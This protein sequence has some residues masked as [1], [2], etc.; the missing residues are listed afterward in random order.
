M[1]SPNASEFQHH[2]RT[3]LASGILCLE[4]CGGEL[5]TAIGCF[6]S[7]AGGATMRDNFSQEARREIPEAEAL[8]AELSSSDSRLRTKRRRRRK[9]KGNGDDGSDSSTT[10]PPRSAR[11]ILSLGADGRIHQSYVEDYNRL[12]QSQGET[13]AAEPTWG[14]GVEEF[15]GVGASVAGT[16]HPGMAGQ[17]GNVEGIGAES[18]GRGVQRRD[19]D[20]QQGVQQDAGGGTSE[21]DREIT[22]EL[23][24]VLDPLS[25]AAQR[26]S[27][28]LSVVSKWCT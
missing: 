24:A 18:E 8:V 21:L 6:S 22:V 20:D 27:T 11:P 2:R 13:D 16:E 9:S 3:F 17:G 7:Y 1:L 23:V 15:R 10:V 19:G 26:A 25:V 5:R 14:E 12:Q 4:C 28:L